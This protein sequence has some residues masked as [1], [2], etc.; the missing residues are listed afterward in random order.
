MDLTGKVKKE[1]RFS[2]AGGGFSDVFK[3]VWRDASQ[4]R[5]VLV[6]AWFHKPE[7]IPLGS[8]QS[9]EIAHRRPGNGESDSTGSFFDLP[10]TFF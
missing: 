9:L 8:Y 5:Q 1:G 4:E 7:L 6:D 3:G 2:V 10:I